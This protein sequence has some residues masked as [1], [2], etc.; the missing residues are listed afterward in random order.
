LFHGAAAH[1]GRQ[2]SAD[3]TSVKNEMKTFLFLTAFAA[4]APLFAQ[5][6]TSPWAALTIRSTVLAK[7]AALEHRPTKAP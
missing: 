4:A 6:A 7:L 2:A 1:S 5:Q 3:V